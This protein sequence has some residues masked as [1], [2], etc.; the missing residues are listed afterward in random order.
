VQVPIECVREGEYVLCYNDQCQPEKKKVLWAGKT[1][2]RE[3]V[4]VNWSCGS[5]KGKVLMTPEHRI[6]LKD[7]L[8]ME[9]QRIQQLLEENEDD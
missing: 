2:D 8:Y 3:V 7:G 9:A 5:E 1:G 6:R 4:E